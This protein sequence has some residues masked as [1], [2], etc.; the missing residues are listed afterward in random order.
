MD[1]TAID[2]K[3]ANRIL[4]LRV[5]TTRI[6][7]ELRYIVEELHDPPDNEQWFSYRRTQCIALLLLASDLSLKLR[8]TA[9]LPPASDDPFNSVAG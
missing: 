7:H 3:L 5:A 1:W 6:D 9:K 8:Q 2:P 4:S